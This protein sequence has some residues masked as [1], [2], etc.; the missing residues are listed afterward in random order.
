MVHRII[1]LSND[2]MVYFFSEPTKQEVFPVS[3][4]E[5]TL[6]SLHYIKLSRGEMS[7][8]NKLFYCQVKG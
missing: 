5:H 2:L 4:G 8:V 6:T 1:I 7:N 3:S